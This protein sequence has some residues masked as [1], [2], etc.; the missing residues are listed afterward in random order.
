MMKAHCDNCDA[1]I[2]NASTKRQVTIQH[3]GFQ[4]LVSVAIQKSPVNDA[5]L[6]LC[7]DCL[8]AALVAFLETVPPTTVGWGDTREKSE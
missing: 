4:C 8:R 1:L 5:Y 6:A 3:Y 2:H 7:S